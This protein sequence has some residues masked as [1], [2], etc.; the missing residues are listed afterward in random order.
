MDK[1]ENAI[2]DLQTQ[3]AFQ[4]GLLEQLNQVVTDQQHYIMRLESRFE[5]MQL[6][7]KSLQTTQASSNDGVEP[8]PPHY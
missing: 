7:I 1:L 2:V 3:L 5:S 6:Q 8:P 4:E